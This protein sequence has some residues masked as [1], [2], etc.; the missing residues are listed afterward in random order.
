M[1]STV[2]ARPDAAQRRAGTGSGVQRQP[3]KTIG[4]CSSPLSARRRAMF[5][6]LG[7]ALGVSFEQR[8]FGDDHNLEGWIVLGADRARAS[9]ISR[10][11][12][13]CYVVLD[14]AELLA[15]GT[16]STVTFADHSEQEEVLRGR[17]VTADDA[18]AARSLPAWLADITPLAFKD[19]STW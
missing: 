2:R 19:G 5:E 10:A 12:R 15:C 7:E 17:V 9:E 14:D 11:T 8:A 4:I 1:A 6:A 3:V 13:P 18:V 16:S